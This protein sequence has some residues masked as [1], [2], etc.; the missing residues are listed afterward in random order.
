MSD[1]SDVDQVNRTNLDATAN[2]CHEM[3]AKEADQ[4]HP[5]AQTHN[6]NDSDLSP[7]PSNPPSNQ[8][9]DFNGKQGECSD[10]GG[11]HC[12]N[13]IASTKHPSNGP[14]NYLKSCQSQLSKITLHNTKP[15]LSRHDRDHCVPQGHPK[16]GDQGRDLREQQEN[17]ALRWSSVPLTAP[18]KVAQRKNSMAQLQQWVNQRRG[19]AFQDNIISPTHYCPVGRGVSADYYRYSAGPQYMEEYLLHP[20]GLRPD[21]MCSVSAVGGYDRG[22]TVDEKRRSLR[23]HLYAPPVPTDQWGQQFY[24]GL[25]TSTKCRSIHPR[26]R[27]LPRSPSSSVGPYSPVPSNFASPARWSTSCFDYF[28]GK[29]KDDVLYVD[30]V[31]NLRR[32]LSSTKCDYPGNRRSLSMGFNHYSHP[33]CPS[34]HNKMVSLFPEV[35]C[36]DL[37]PTLKLNEIETSKLLQRLCEQNQTLKDHKAI[38]HRLRMEKDSLEEMLV[39]THQ[40]ME[41]YLNQPLAMGKLQL[42]K[43]T[44][45]NQLIHIRGELSEASSAFNTTRM[46]FEALEDEANAIHGDLWEQLNEGGQSELVHRHVQKEF[47]RVQDVLEELHN[48][49]SPRGTSTAKHRVISG[50]SGSFSTNSPAS[51]LSSISIPSPLSPYSPVPGFQASPQ[52]QVGLDEI[53]PPRPPLPKSY[54]PLDQLST[55][56]PSVPP[57]PFDSTDCSSRFGIGD[58]YHDGEDPY[59]RKLTFGEQSNASVVLNQVQDGSFIMNKVGIVTPR[60]KSPT[61]QFHSSSAEV[62]QYRMHNG[63][64]KER[65]NSAVFTTE[66]KSKMSVEEQNERIRRNQSSSV[67]D[68]RR[69]LNLSVAQPPAS[70]KVIRR[71]LTAHEIDIK[72]LEAAVQGQGHESPQEEIARLRRLQVEPEYYDFNFSKELLAPEKVLIPERCLDVEDDSPLSQEEQKEKE[73]KLERIK[74]LIVKS[75][76]QNMVPLLDGPAE[77][78]SS[79][80]SQLQLQEQEKRIE[81]S[82]ALAAEASRRSRLLSAQCVT[83]HRTSLASL[84]SLPTSADVCSST[85]II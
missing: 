76:L 50:A 2:L 81:I 79:V 38:I 42:K 60:A 84:A 62:S 74:T 49:Q 24:S 18:E 59:I 46:E 29:I 36:R 52:K 40:K 25:E 47:W 12:P 43:E 72:H 34:T 10:K 15:P 48:N 5:D 77:G 20:P 63:I 56:P 17:D 3:V 35:Y 8:E 32:S 39:A 1:A 30:S 16:G 61:D 83:S 75:N 53:V 28:P 33:V 4:Q 27:S 82:C 51:P 44:L 7:K 55:S 67:K 41:L 23:D 37:H 11:G 80:S 58:C 9:A 70:Y 26:S 73:K 22:W 21:S 85:H 54:S 19:M 13:Y 78:G 64:S 45:Q 14:D 57:L 6:N 66:V 71:Q 69:S 65:P 31:Y 68:K